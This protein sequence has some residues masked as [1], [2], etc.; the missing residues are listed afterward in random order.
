MLVLAVCSIS[1]RFSTHPQINTEPA[2]LRGEEWAAPA[3]DII[4]RRYDEPNITIITVLLLLGLHEFGTCQGGRSWMFAGMAERMAYALQLHRELD[5]DPLGKRNDKESELSFTDR[6]IRRRTMWACFLMD[7]FTASGTERPMSADEESI[8]V[9]LPIKETHFQMDISGPTES[10]DGRVPNPVTTDTGQLADAKANMGV[11]AY[12]IRVIAL[13]SRVIK[14]LNMG[15]KEKD[16]LPMWEPKSQYSELKR[17]AADFTSTL[18]A[19]LQNT[20]DNLHNHAAERLANQFI[21]LHVAANQVILFLHRFAIPTS[22]GA[23]NPSKMPTSFLAEAGPVA[24]KAASKI[25]VLLVDALEHNAVA[26]FISYC[27][28]LSGTV[29]VWGIFSKNPLLEIS[30]K[31]SLGSN[32]KYLSK[33]ERYWG[34]CPFMVKNLKDIYREHA[35]ASLKGTGETATQDAAIFQYGDWFTRYPH[36]VSRTDYEDNTKIKKEPVDDAALSQ[37]S[38]LQTVEDF[39]QTLSP[40]SSKPNNSKK[41]SRK[42]TKI[43]STQQSKNATQLP[44]PHLHMDTIPQQPAVVPMTMVDP[45]QHPM[46]PFTPTHPQ[47]QPQ[48]YP[49]PCNNTYPAPHDLLPLH[50]PANTALLPRLDRSLVYDAYAGS[51]DSPESAM[52]N[53]PQYTPSSAGL[54]WDG[55]GMDMQQQQQQQQMMAQGGIPDVNSAGGYMS[56]MQ[57]SAWFMPFNMIPPGVDGAEEMGPMGN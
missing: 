11:A 7:R 31:E 16:P 32:V 44:H 12:M 54:M 48:L 22:P 9:Q 10:L 20:R 55:S 36:G 6:E 24:V 17:Q 52:G 3:R 34:M 26:P 4:I 43:A 53:L 18:P 37:K 51:N 50:T 47:S 46:T 2:F 39:F 5:H 25:S 15:G 29:H 27:A 42:N 19:E 33:M 57:T 40:S 13:W 21:F 23:R 49:H 35:D 30:C 1:A 41:T 28:F 56:D 8:K 45:H 38:D 14:H